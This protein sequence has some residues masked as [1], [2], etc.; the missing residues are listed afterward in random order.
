MTEQE[1]FDKV[2]AH[3]RKQGVKSVENGRCRYRTAEGL[4]CA[5]GILI[6]DEDYSTELEGCVVYN[7]GVLKATGLG[8]GSPILKKLAT[9]L[10]VVHDSHEP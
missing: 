10:Q 1:L 2:V 4:K 5:I 9:A 6:K 7:S 8:G 3:L